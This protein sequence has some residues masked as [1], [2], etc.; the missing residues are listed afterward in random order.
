MNRP[1]LP[2]SEQND[3]EGA[4]PP[5]Q[6]ESLVKEPESATMHM[7]DGNFLTVPPNETPAVNGPDKLDPNLKLSPT[8]L[9]AGSVL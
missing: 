8:L 5:S 9:D 6:L 3:T 7:T 2:T 4:M 1:Q